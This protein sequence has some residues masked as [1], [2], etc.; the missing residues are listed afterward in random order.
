MANFCY[1]QS[2]STFFSSERR[3][4]LPGKHRREGIACRKGGEA[5]IVDA[6][7]RAYWHDGHGGR[8]RRIG[9]L[10][11]R[12]R[13]QKPRLCYRRRTESSLALSTVS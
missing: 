8:S 3:E 11:R 12:C 10:R 13:R 4:E 9:R 7:R 1:N 2:K 5:K 6:L